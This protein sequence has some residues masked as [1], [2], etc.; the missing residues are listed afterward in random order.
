ME[1]INITKEEIIR[2]YESIQGTGNSPYQ[3]RFYYKQ[4]KKVKNGKS[5]LGD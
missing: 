5:R 4:L 1:T 3:N 2:V